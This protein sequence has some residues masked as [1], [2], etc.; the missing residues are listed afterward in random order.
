MTCQVYGSSIVPSAQTYGTGALGVLGSVIEATTGEGTNG[1]GVLYNDVVADSAGNANKEFQPLLTAL[2]SAGSFYL[3]PDGSFSFT[4]APDGTYTFKY[5]PKADGQAY[6]AEQTVTLLVGVVSSF[7]GNLTEDP[8]VASGT[9]AMFVSSFSGALTTEDASAAGTFT[10]LG[11]S[12]FVGVLVSDEAVASGTFTNFVSAFSG[13]ITSADDVVSGNFTGIILSVFEGVLTLANDRAT[14]SFYSEGGNVLD[15]TSPLGRVRLKIGDYSDTPILP[16]AVIYAALVDC[17]D[18]INR[19]SALCAQYILGAL[20]AKTHKKLAQ[21]E[22]WSAQQFDNYVKFLQLTILNPN[23]TTVAPVPYAGAGDED[24]PIEQF[25]KDW[26]DG[27][28]EG[29]IVI[30]P[31]TPG[32]VIEYAF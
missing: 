15:P 23:L 30:P 13:A 29:S 12:S 5:I 20:T 32:R 22:T 19:A 6:A 24:H 11:P 18:N 31:Q 17:N 9:F 28:K 21:L 27:Y 3:Y 4:G 16:D 26:K 25:V 10:S 2:P 14:G 7:V 8:A 1:A